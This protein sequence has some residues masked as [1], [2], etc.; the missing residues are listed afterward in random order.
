M[1]VLTSFGLDFIVICQ[2]IGQLCE[3][4]P[5]EHR[6]CLLLLDSSLFSFFLPF[7]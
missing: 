2:V 6:D 4:P 1:R 7:V 3:L 5:L